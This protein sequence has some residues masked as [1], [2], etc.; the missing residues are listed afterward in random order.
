MTYSNPADHFLVTADVVELEQH[1]GRL[2]QTHYPA[3]SRASVARP[4]ILCE[5][6]MPN[7]WELQRDLRDMRYLNVLV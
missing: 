1:G 5:I 7:L 3:Q 2:V 4:G 6:P